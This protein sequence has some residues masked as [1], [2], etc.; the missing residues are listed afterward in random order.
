MS[1]SEFCWIAD[2]ENDPGEAIS[3]LEERAVAVPVP[4]KSDSKSFFS[5]CS[6]E[7]LPKDMPDSLDSIEDLISL[8]SSI[9]E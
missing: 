6:V 8:D 7:I 5:S 2:V 4:S 9:G 1:K 3:E